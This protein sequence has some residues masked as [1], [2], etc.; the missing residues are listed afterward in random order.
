MT[1]KTYKITGF[2]DE[3]ANELTTQVTELKKLDMHYVEMRGVD[4]DNLIFHSDEKISIFKNSKTIY[5]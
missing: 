2:A 1:K 4:G 5:G 3:I